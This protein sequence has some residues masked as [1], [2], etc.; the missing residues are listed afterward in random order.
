MQHTTNNSSLF[1]DN[2]QNTSSGAEL[3]GVDSPDKLQDLQEQEKPNSDQPIK[4][5]TSQVVPTP[6]EQEME[7]T[8]I[9]EESKSS[10]GT[11]QSAEAFRPAY[12]KAITT[13]TVDIKN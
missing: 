2:K 8:K 4:E 6:N 3:S 1:V 5:S 7:E 12:Y 13:S 9:D 10:Q 11:S